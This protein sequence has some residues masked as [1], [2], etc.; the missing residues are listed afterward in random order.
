M[1]AEDVGAFVKLASENLEVAAGAGLPPWPRSRRTRSEDP[2][3]P[4]DRRRRA[5]PEKAAGGGG[6]GDADGASGGVAKK[7]RAVNGP[8]GEHTRFAS[9][10]ATTGVRGGR[11][12]GLG[13]RRPRAYGGGWVKG[14]VFQ[15]NT[16]RVENAVARRL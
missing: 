6:G 8:G 2:E 3:K 4:E 13:L 5:G 12:H 1:A 10:P 11:R 9:T 15:Y 7:K 14:R 16:R